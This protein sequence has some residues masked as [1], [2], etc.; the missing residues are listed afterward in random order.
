MPIFDV[1]Q[2]K[3]K[4][5]LSKY[6]YTIPTK[7]LPHNIEGVVLN[8]ETFSRYATKHYKE[9]AIL[10]LL[11]G[12]DV[13]CEDGVA[14]IRWDHDVKT[15]L[16]FGTM[17]IRSSNNISRCKNIWKEYEDVTFDN[18][19]YHELKPITSRSK[20][21]VSNLKFSLPNKA[22]TKFLNKTAKALLTTDYIDTSAGKYKNKWKFNTKKREY[23]M[24]YLNKKIPLHG[25]ITTNTSN[26]SWREL[27]IDIEG[28]T[29]LSIDGNP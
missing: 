15:W 4:V 8:I 16:D 24:D 25:P 23:D 5:I 26:R 29:S 11:A 21:A 12:N 3:I 10:E 6:Y 22:T 17:I 28:P 19:K 18:R 2:Y 13:S 20:I 9:G 7:H 1:A 14:R 27:D